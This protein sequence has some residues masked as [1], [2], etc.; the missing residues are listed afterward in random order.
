MLV[1]VII[2]A[3]ALIP[4]G[5]FWWLTDVFL[6]SELGSIKSGDF[7]VNTIGVPAIYYF[8]KL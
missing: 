2:L 5:D 8:K 4:T 1:T 6:V 7:Q 3:V